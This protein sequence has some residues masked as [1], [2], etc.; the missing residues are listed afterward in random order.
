[1][2]TNIEK[3]KAVIKQA[4]G[5]DRYSLAD[6]LLAIDKATKESSYFVDSEGSFHE[7]FAPKGRLDLQTITKWNLKD[8]NL[9][10]QSE[11]TINF[12]WE[13]LHV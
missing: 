7:W 13:L 10:N 6:V 5:S 9:D 11:E 4:G 3:L 1:M 12:L 8:D 2:E